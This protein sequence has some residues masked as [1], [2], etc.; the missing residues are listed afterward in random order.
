MLYIRK[1]GSKRKEEVNRYDGNAGNK[2][3]QPHHFREQVLHEA[4]ELRRDDRRC[5]SLRQQTVV[6]VHERLP[7]ARRHPPEQG[8]IAKVFPRPLAH[9]AELLAQSRHRIIPQAK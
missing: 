7:D 8:V 6:R 1:D 2:T 5:S 3:D 4:D 9:I